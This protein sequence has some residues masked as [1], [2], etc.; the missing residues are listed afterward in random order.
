MA[1]LLRRLKWPRKQKPRRPPPTK[2]AKAPKGPGVISTIIECISKEKGATA[3]EIVA[4]LVKVFPDRR[5]MAGEIPASCEIANAA[6]ERVKKH[7]RRSSTFSVTS[8][9]R[10]AIGVRRAEPQPL[11]RKVLYRRGG[12]SHALSHGLS[13]DLPGA[14]PIVP[15]AR[16]GRRRRFS[17]A[18]KRQ[19]LLERCG[20]M[21][22]SPRWLEYS[23]T[24]YL[25]TIGASR[26]RSN[27]S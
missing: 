18:D 25:V 7:L 4:V 24:Y 23:N 1:A 26:M 21:R 15:P 11:A 13:H 9:R 20:W 8:E 27:A 19:I 6:N 22:A 3:D 10:S 16:E 17:E 12:L 5:K 14:S 2:A